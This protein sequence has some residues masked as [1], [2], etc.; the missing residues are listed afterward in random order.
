MN[1]EEVLRKI[2]ELDEKFANP[3]FPEDKDSIKALRKRVEDAIL[4][5]SLKEHEGIKEILKYL[6]GEIV[7]INEALLNNRPETLPD[8]TR[9]T[10]FDKKDLF[11]W[12]ISLFADIN[13]VLTEVKQETEEQ[14]EHYKDVYEKGR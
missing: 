10:L 4:Y 6:R 14:L 12:F 8:K 7:Q 3:A 1:P 2:D 5:K 9:E 11:I 13:Q